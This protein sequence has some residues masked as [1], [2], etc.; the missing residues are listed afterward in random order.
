MQI[1]SRDKSSKWKFSLKLELLQYR[2]TISRGTFFFCLLSF[3]VE[4]SWKLFNL[5]NRI[6]Y[7]RQVTPSA[8]ETS[9]R[10]KEA[11]EIYTITWLLCAFSLV[12]DRDLLE[13]T[14]THITV[15]RHITSADLFFFLFP[16]SCSINHLNYIFPCACQDVAACK[17]QQSGHSIVVLFVLYTLWR[18]L[19]SI[20]GLTTYEDVMVDLLKMLTILQMYL[21]CKYLSY[22]LGGY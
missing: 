21:Q 9:L 10:Q 8:V 16:K 11:I 7:A 3:C 18:Y 15:P 19:W 4:W 22:H 6:L 13:D 1:R 2:H 17:E 12:V 14:H 20:R 5:T